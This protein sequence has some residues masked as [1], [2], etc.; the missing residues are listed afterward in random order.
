M[1]NAMRLGELTDE[2]NERLKQLA[3]PVHYTDGLEPCQ[4]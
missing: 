4:L 1:L 2:H 3:Q